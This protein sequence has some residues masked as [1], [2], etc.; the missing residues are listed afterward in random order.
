[1]S[2]HVAILGAGCDY[3]DLGGLYS[4]TAE[5]LKLDGRFRRAG[6]LAVHLFPELERR[7]CSFE[8]EAA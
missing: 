5:Q 2:F 8:L 1:V 6:R 3:L 7:G 4:M